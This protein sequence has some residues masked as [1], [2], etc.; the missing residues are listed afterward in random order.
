MAFDRFTR[1]GDGVV[2]VFARRKA[3]RDIRDF[4]APGVLVVTGEDRDREQH[5]DESPRQLA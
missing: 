2:E 5:G 4:H 3:A 1:H